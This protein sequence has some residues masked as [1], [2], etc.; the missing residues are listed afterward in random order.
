MF[1]EVFACLE[2]PV[3][4][5]QCLLGFASPPNSDVPKVGLTISTASWYRRTHRSS[6]DLILKVAE[7]GV[8]RCRARAPPPRLWATTSHTPLT[9]SHEPTSYCFTQS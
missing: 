7:G 6:M 8:A 4:L 1:Q 9:A 5:T 2:A 3:K